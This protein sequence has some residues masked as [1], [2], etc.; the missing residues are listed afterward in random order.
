MDAQ[1]LL[2]ILIIVIAA[3]FYFLF[4]QI[5]SL[6]EKDSGQDMLLKWLEDSRRGNESMQ[7]RIDQVNKTINDRLD[8]A[9]AV[10]ADVKK[11]VGQMNEIG[12][13][14]KELQDFLRSPKLRGNLGE[15]VLKELL[16]QFLPKESF[17]LQ[18]RF[19]SGE[20]VDAAIKTESGIIP[21]DSKF[22][23]G[24]FQNMIKAETEAEKKVFEK[25]FTRDVKRH[26]DDIA[27]KYIL[28]DEGTID[29]ALMY[30]PSESVY[31]EIVGHQEISDHAY[32]KRVLTVSPATFYAY[33][34][35]ILMSFEGKRIEETA[36][37]ILTTLR[38]IKGESEKFGDTLK[39]L[40]KHV[41]EAKNTTDIANVRY[42]SLHSKIDTASGLKGPSDKALPEE[43]PSLEEAEEITE[44]R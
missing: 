32:Q 37:T 11:E 40:T 28:P 27:K 14:M 8:R 42:T 7:S 35:A 24:N 41:N 26:I 4:R 25:D 15:Q 13:S 29:Y 33:M 6:K 31:Y 19:R 23:L 36:K 1:T 17:H 21:I 44:E 22:P 10:V 18:Y 38:A 43:V 9:A 20:I 39:V 2:I 12:R 3:S 34:R 16:G 5:Q 30:I